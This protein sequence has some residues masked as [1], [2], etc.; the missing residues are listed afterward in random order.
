MSFLFQVHHNWAMI[1]KKGSNTWLRLSIMVIDPYIVDH[2]HHFILVYKPYIVL[3]QL[4]LQEET[5]A[6]QRKMRV[7][8]LI[9]VGCFV[10]ELNFLIVTECSTLFL[11][12]LP[13]K[14]M[15]CLRACENEYVPILGITSLLFFVRS[16]TC[17]GYHSET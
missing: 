11:L 12:F 1:L 17:A 3:R 15:S 8:L 14:Y 13:V 2:W 6:I 4:S 10:H 7:P 16:H 5:S 9:I